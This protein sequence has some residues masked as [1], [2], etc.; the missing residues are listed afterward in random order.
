MG[1][2]FEAGLSGLHPGSVMIAAG[3]DDG[4]RVALVAEVRNG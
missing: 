1:W 4:K 3:E 2:D